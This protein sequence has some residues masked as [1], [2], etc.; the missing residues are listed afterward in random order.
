MTAPALPVGKTLGKL[1]AMEQTQ[2]K[3]TSKQDSPAHGLA[4]TAHGL[5][6]AAR[7]GL[8]NKKIQALM[9]ATATNL[10][11]TETALLLLLVSIWHYRNIK[12]PKAT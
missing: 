12:H 10:K 1:P 7:G 6:R 4:K 8:T 5:Y 11:R 9:T 3:K 2:K